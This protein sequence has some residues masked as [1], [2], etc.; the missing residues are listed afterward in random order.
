MLQCKAD[1]KI[2]I[3]IGVYGADVGSDRELSNDAL[4]SEFD[5]I[6]AAVVEGELKTEAD[7]A[8]AA[9]AVVNE[10]RKLGFTS[11]DE[12]LEHVLI[13]I[14][15]SYRRATRRVMSAPPGSYVIPKNNRCRASFHFFRSRV[16]VWQRH[17]QR[18][19]MN[20]DVV[21]APAVTTNTE[22]VFAKLPYFELGAM[23]K[24]VVGKPTPQK[25]LFDIDEPVQPPRER[26]ATSRVKSAKPTLATSH[27]PS[28]YSRQ[29][30]KKP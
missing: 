22:S 10:P 6:T 24:P 16:G 12:P 25:K 5:R 8:S 20:N 30:I 28:I 23:Q 29:Q 19:M 9:A 14:V 2:C 15:C 21:P 11:F 1:F 4:L 7:T 26:S 13:F 18:P 3:D 17:L 27:L